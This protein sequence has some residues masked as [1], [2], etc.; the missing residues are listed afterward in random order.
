[1]AGKDFG[2][3]GCGALVVLVEVLASAE[4]T[5]RG[6]L[7]SHTCVGWVPVL[8]AVLALGVIVTRVLPEEAA[9]AVE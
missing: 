5:L 8:H 6:F 1:M 7:V 3:T 9:A 4:S 2:A